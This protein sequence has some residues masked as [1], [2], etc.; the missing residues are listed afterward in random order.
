M[1]ILNLYAGIGGN[2]KLWGDEHEITAVEKDW[3]VAS[4]YRDFFPRD[5]VVVEDAH[6]YLLTHYKNYDFIWASPPCPTHSKAR[7]WGS[8]GGQV[9]PVYPDM[10]LY[11]E[12]LFL[13]HFFIG[14]WVVEN[15]DPYYSPLIPT[16]KFGRHLI[17]SNFVIPDFDKAQAFDKDSMESMTA[18]YGFDLSKYKVPEKQKLLRNCTEPELGKHILDWAMNP[19]YP[20]MRMAI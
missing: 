19:Y 14:K 11:Q 6:E 15:V 16:D 8:K 10:T 9:A 17:W 5:T 4:I 1:R 20:T 18:H 12:I 13:K 7:F 2:R 3:N